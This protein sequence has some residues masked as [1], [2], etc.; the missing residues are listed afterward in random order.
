M[1]PKK[2]LVVILTAMVILFASGMALSACGDEAEDA[3]DAGPDSRNSE[4]PA[5]AQRGSG[6][7]AADFDF[8]MG[9]DLYAVPE[10]AIPAR[11]Q[12]FN[13]PNF[14]TAITRVTDIDADGIEDPGI[15]N[16]Y[17]RA[18][19]ENS[20]GSLLILRGN[21]GNWYLYDAESFAMIERLPDEMLDAPEFE[22]RWD[23]DDP[24]V[25]YYLYQTELRS[26]NTD[27]RA[28]ATVHDFATDVP[29]AAYIT[30]GS[31]GDASLDRSY[32][33]FM[34]EDDDGDTMAVVTYDRDNDSLA[35]RFTDF[36]GGI[37]YVSMDMSGSHCI[38]GWDERPMEAFSPD[39]STSV[40]LPEG[41][42]GHSD[43][44]RTVDGRDVLVYQNT[45]TDWIAMADLD[46]G[47]ETNLI[48]IP[49]E[50]NT[51]IGLHISGNSS[52]TPGWVLVST[53]GSKEPPPD[54]EHSWMD[55]QLFLLELRQ[56]GRVW[57]IADT[58]CY[59]SLEYDAEKNYF[60]EAF[61]AINTTGTRVYFASNWEDM[62][63]EY[64]DVYVV[65]LPD[66]WVSA[67][68]Q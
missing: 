45:A 60:A 53:Y 10:L 12:T 15:S 54:G 8:V 63:E 68:P 57:R 33:C 19:P 9:T 32:W 1:K 59:T 30:T 34:A 47:E 49:F 23:P 40:D 7:S 56:N 61:A 21:G 14:N 11:G 5:A 39:L 18:D 37:D 16:E 50:I 44:T 51:D 17:A 29:G 31:E 52:A 43:F 22:P 35:G 27:A 36:S 3:G 25:F 28:S 6:V 46:T 13:D 26:Y 38:I 62:T 58:H 4:L 64:T 48:P 41:V 42:L 20:D 2:S 24:T 66:G 65:D 55:E 67:V